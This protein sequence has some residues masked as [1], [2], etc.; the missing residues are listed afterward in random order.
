MQSGM[1]LRLFVF[2]SHTCGFVT[3]LCKLSDFFEKLERI[4]GGSGM[5]EDTIEAAR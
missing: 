2:K 3:M 5:L 1:G 4:R